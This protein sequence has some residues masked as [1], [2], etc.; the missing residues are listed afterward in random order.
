M[1]V[2]AVQMLTLDKLPRR[3]LAGMDIET[4]FKASRCVIAAERLQLFRVLGDKA[5]TAV[6]IGRRVGLNKLHCRTFLDVLAVL[7]LLAKTGG[8]YRLSRT[9]RKYFIT[10]RGAHWSRLWSKYC[11]DDFAA[12]SVLEQSLTSG[13]DY[14]KLLG[15]K[16]ESDYEVLR[17]DQTWAEDF[18]RIMH[19]TKRQVSVKLAHHLDLSGYR[20]LLDVGGGSGIMAMELARRHPDLRACVQDFG[21]VCKAAR[22]II[23]EMGFSKRITTFAADMTKELATGYDVIMYWDV[24]SVPLQSFK[25]AHSAL[26]P[27]G[28]LLVGGCF[29][30]HEERSL[31]LL[32]RKL[33]LIYP[34]HDSLIE[35]ASKLRTAGFPRSRRRRIEGVGWVVTAHRDHESRE[36]V[37]AD[38]SAFI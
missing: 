22:K 6:E 24:G 34:D 17:H 28:M 9:A 23:K 36:G 3:T 21:P 35:T 32:T 30:D 25:L 13:R 31:N 29:S 26:P 8:R 33:S 27:G 4:A 7:G 1:E 14:R 11:A 12:F 37:R 20:A 38:R 2:D 16:R 10:E 15:V 5:L 19:D 18:T